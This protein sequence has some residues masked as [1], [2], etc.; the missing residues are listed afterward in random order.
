MRAIAWIVLFITLAVPAMAQLPDCAAVQGWQQNGDGRSYEPDNL[1]DY[2]NGNAE[3]YNLYRFVGMKG[4]TCKCGEDTIVIDISEMANPE[5]AYGIFAANRDA[6][7]A[8]EKL[9]TIGQIT[10][11]KA[12]F[13]KDKYYVELAASPEKDHREALKA[14]AAI[15]EKNLQGSSSP[16][17]ALSWFPKAGLTP[18]SAR[19]VPESVLGLRILESGYVAQY[20]VGKAFVVR[21]SSPDE[22]AQVMAKW[23]ERIGQTTPAELGEEA[24]T[25]TDRYLDGLYVFRKGP[26]LAGFAN[27]KPGTDVKDRV[28][29]LAE[30]L[31]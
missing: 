3:G 28:R 16:P 14:F 7:Q 1:F 11:R 26:Y 24:F 2:M 21:E 4:I 20:D 10:P 19:L 9:G 23:K 5:F 22:A 8:T 17:A 29:E 27:L 12:V 13:V 31:K 15:M 6:R 18:E 25:A 30:N